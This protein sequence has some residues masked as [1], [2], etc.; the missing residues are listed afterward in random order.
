M[1]R[2]THLGA[3]VG[4]STSGYGLPRLHGQRTRCVV[5]VVVY[6]MPPMN[7]KRILVPWLVQAPLDMDSNR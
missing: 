1:N 3:L 4:A 5:Q 2:K 7:R 6:K